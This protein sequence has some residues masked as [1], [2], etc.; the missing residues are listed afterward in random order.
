MF[1]GGLSIGLSG[2]IILVSEMDPPEPEVFVVSLMPQV[3]VSGVEPV[4]FPIVSPLP[5]PSE[6]FAPEVITELLDSKEFKR[7]DCSYGRLM[8][9]FG[10]EM[11]E[12][13]KKLSSCKTAAAGT[14]FARAKALAKCEES[15]CSINGWVKG[16]DYI[17]PEDYG[18]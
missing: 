9:I 15:I 11:Y 3:F 18:I 14:Y 6:K 8:G 13:E 2:A 17:E 1:V 5:V 12:V 7:K 4:L 16:R 10:S